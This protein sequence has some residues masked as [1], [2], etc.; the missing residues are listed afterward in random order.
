MEKKFTVRPEIEVNLS[1]Q[2]IRDIVIIALEGGIGYWACLDDTGA[3][4]DEPVSEQAA[5]VLLTGGSLTFTDAE[6]DPEDP[7]TESWILTLDKLLNGIK[8]YFEDGCHVSVE[9]N[10]IDTCDVDANDADCMVQ[11]ALFGEVVYG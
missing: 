9:D 3:S 6:S 5:D 11:F 10:A 4:G 1:E 7:S 2:D 8:L